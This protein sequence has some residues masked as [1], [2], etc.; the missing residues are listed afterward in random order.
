M[1][2]PLLNLLLIAGII[3]LARL[4]T[5]FGLFYELVITTLIL[6]A[7][8]LTFRYW[9]WLAQFLQDRGWMESPYAEFGSYWILFLVGC[10]PLVWL[11]RFLTDESRPLYPKWLDTLGGAALGL[12]GGILLACVI[13]TSVTVLGPT[14]SRRYDRTMLWLPYDTT[15]ITAYRRLEERMGAPATTRL[16]DF[17]SRDPANPILPWH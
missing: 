3:Y 7:S 11:A 4:G 1:F 17:D 2:E 16:P 5:L 14:F 9:F 15:A 12:A 13:V 6:F 10:L 8:L